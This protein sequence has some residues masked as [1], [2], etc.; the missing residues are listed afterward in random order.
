MNEQTTQLIEQL[1]AKLGTTAEYIWATLIR[2]API[3][4]TVT[5]IQII[6]ILL[7]GWTL[8]ETHMH[9]LTPTDNDGYTRT[10]YER[11]RDL[12]SIPML[13]AGIVFAILIIYALIAISDV[14]NGYVNPEYWAL[15]RIL[16]NLK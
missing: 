15:E 2:Q 10:G 4:A 14:A 3:E 12:A 13:I 6:L 8:Y 1:A 5:L 7:F 11:H 9:L 16:I